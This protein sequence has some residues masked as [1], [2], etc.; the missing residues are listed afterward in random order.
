MNPS[1]AHGSYEYESSFETQNATDASHVSVPT[2]VPTMCGSVKYGNDRESQGS[3][4]Q[5]LALCFCLLN[6]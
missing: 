4:G 5:I 6:A 1:S 3:A 2:N